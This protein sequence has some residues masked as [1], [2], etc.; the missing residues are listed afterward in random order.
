MIDALSRRH[1]LLS[2]LKTKVFGLENIKDLYASDSEF[3]SKLVYVSMMPKNGY[4]RH[5][6]N[7]FKEK[8]LCV[9]KGPI[10]ELLVSEACEGG[11]MGNFGVFKTLDLLQEHFYW[12][13]MI[14]DVQ[15]FCENVLFVKRQ[16]L[17]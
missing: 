14:I 12:P 2:T 3:S 11:L 13:H 6:D 5:N 9:P 8:R 7:L 16:N 17:R 15:K 4:F 1:V 10:R